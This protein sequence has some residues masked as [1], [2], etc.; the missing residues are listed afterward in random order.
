MIADGANLGVVFRAGQMRYADQGDAGPGSAAADTR[1]A[2]MSELLG[3][4]IWPDDRI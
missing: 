4:T 1:V 3:F 2:M